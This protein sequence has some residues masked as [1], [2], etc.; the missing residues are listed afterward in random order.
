LWCG[1]W[2]MERT[3]GRTIREWG[4]QVGKRSLAE[5]DLLIRAHAQPSPPGV[6]TRFLWG[7]TRY[8]TSVL[9]N[10]GPGPTMAPKNVL[11]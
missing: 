9:H 3:G 2:C 10:T 8:F 11:V 7:N 5:F 1:A 4:I 6:L